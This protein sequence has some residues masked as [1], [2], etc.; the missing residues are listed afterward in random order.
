ME[1][2]SST[3]LIDLI[4][5]YDHFL[6]EIQIQFE[7]DVQDLNDLVKNRM[8]MVYL[9]NFFEEMLNKLNKMKIV[10]INNLFDNEY[11]Q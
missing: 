5:I 4:E 9:M 7:E 6:M 10:M 8:I 11:L 1:M 3:V 2:N